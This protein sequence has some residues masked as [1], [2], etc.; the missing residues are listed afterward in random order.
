MLTFFQIFTALS[1]L[2][3]LIVVN[4]LYQ[5]LRLLN[6]RVDIL[7]MLVKNI[8][9]DFEANLAANSIS[10]ES[11]EEIIDSYDRID[12]ELNKKLR[13]DFSLQN[14]STIQQQQPT[15]MN[16]KLQNDVTSYISTSSQVENIP[17]F[18]LDSLAS[19]EKK[20][21]QP[22]NETDSAPPS[23]TSSSSKKE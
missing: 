16:L 15:N 5:A 1:V 11:L 12:N 3:L 6:S 21:P 9:R 14:L 23:Q 19:E 8:R 10:S 2:I 20:N 13:R 18:A 22:P 17:D 4:R 7:S